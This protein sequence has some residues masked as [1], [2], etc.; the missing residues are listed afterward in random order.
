MK[1]TNIYKGKLPFQSEFSHKHACWTNNHR[2]WAKMKKS[3]KRIA[4]RKL[5]QEWLRIITVENLVKEM[6]CD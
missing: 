6:E 3:N 1:K 5:K 2:G 4:K